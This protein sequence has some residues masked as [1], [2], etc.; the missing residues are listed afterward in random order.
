[1]KITLINECIKCN[2]FT[3]GYYSICNS[4]VYASW[5]NNNRTY[6][7]IMKSTIKEVREYIKTNFIKYM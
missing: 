6:S 4:G 5:Q 2:G 1:M 3:V 7:N